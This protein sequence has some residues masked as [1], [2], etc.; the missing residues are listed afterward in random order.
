M[1]HLVSNVFLAETMGYKHLRKILISTLPMTTVKNTHVWETDT[2]YQVHVLATG[3]VV[4]DSRVALSVKRG[5]E[6]GQSNLI[7]Y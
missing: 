1:F 5:I 2:T 3:M 4:I 6:Y 7:H